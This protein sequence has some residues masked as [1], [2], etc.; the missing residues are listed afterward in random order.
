MLTSVTSCD[1]AGGGE[2]RKKLRQ[3]VPS[4]PLKKKIVYLQVFQ[5]AV[6]SLFFFCLFVRGFFF[7]QMENISTPTFVAQVAFKSAQFWRKVAK[8]GAI[9]AQLLLRGGGEGRQSCFCKIAP[10]PPGFATGRRKF[11][12]KKVLI[13]KKKWASVGGSEPPSL[14]T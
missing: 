3:K 5:K 7:F 6:E 12:Q 8:L 4:T 10:L 14:Q 2:S 1:F 13:A 9:G 11:S